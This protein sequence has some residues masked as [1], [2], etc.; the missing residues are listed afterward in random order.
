VV[1]GYA[2]D[3]EAVAQEGS[4]ID[5]QEEPEVEKPQLPPLSKCQEEE[6]A[7]GAAVGHLLSLNMWTY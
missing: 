5:A 2:Y 6:L 7:V 3:D 1:A 4:Q